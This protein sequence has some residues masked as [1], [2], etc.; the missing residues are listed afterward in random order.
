MSGFAGVRV[1]LRVVSDLHNTAAPSPG[2]VTP[3]TKGGPELLRQER[4]AQSHP[5][6][7]MQQ[8]TEQGNR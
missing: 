3:K 6:Q 2:K 7:L 4:G 8:E 1:C 5:T